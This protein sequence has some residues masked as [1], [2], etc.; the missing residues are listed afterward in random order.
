MKFTRLQN[1]FFTILV[2]T[3]LLGNTNGQYGYYGGYNNYYYPQPGVMTTSTQNPP[4]PP[5]TTS[6]PRHGPRGKR[7]IM[8]NFLNASTTFGIDVNLTTPTT[9]NFLNTTK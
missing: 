2:L 3:L 5:T 1:I 7:Q 6:I 8:E 9:N 4:P